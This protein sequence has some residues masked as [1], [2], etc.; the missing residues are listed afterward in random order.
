MLVVIESQQKIPSSAGQVRNGTRNDRCPSK[1]K[2]AL[3]RN[4]VEDHIKYSTTL[5][6][7]ATLLSSPQEK[8]AV[9][10]NK[11]TCDLD[12]YHLLQGPLPWLDDIVV[13]QP[14]APKIQRG[15]TLSAGHGLMNL[16]KMHRLIFYFRGWIFFGSVQCGGGA[17]TDQIVGPFAHEVIG[18]FS[19][20]EQLY[21]SIIDLYGI[22]SIGIA[23]LKFGHQTLPKILVFHATQWHMNG[24]KTRSRSHGF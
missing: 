8:Y 17:G 2:T 10:L 14:S 6:S 12:S 4:Q 9:A 13:S 18:A 7:R 20:I 22:F 15:N 19:T 11:Q 5:F 1:G 24:P 21:N 3:Q 23:Y 16:Y